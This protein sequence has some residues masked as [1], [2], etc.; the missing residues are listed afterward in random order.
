VPIKKDLG[1]QNP[2]ECPLCFSSSS[3]F[4]NNENRDYFL[5]PTCALVFVP[6]EFFLTQKQEVER[7]LE[8]KNTIE[9]EGYVAMFEGAI[10]LIKNNCQNINVVLDYGCGYAPILKA[11]LERHG[12]E[13][14][15]YDENFFADKEFRLGYDLIVSTETFEH[16]NFPG[17]ELDRITSMLFSTSYLAIMTQFYP[18]NN[19][20]PSEEV[21][22]NWYYKRDPTHIVFYSSKTFEWIARH[23][24][25]KIVYNNNKNFVILQKLVLKILSSK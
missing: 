4:H 7:Y 9:N 2:R 15:I 3:F 18:L 23:Y 20:E 8:H 16:F 24:E 25:F 6:P 12:F 22:K 13:V 5:C 10:S 11:L 19:E 14:D 17:K 1:P 21:F